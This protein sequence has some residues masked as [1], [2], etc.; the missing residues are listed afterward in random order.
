MIRVSPTKS[1]LIETKRS[2][3]LA[4]EGHTLLDKKR[5]VLIRE[6]MQLIDEAKEVQ[7]QTEKVFEV[8][9]IQSHIS[10]GPLPC[11]PHVKVLS[12]R[13]TPTPLVSSF[14]NESST[15]LSSWLPAP[16]E[17]N[18][19]LEL[20]KKIVE[21]K[22]DFFA[23]LQACTEQKDKVIDYL[24]K[25]LE[26]VRVDAKSKQKTIVSLQSAVE[27]L[28]TTVAL[29]AARL[30]ILSQADA[31]RSK[32]TRELIDEVCELRD[33]SSALV[34]TVKQR[35]QQ[36][37]T[38][39]KHSLELEDVAESR[40]RQIKRVTAYVRLTLAAQEQQAAAA[41]AVAI[42]P[43]KGPESARSTHS[44]GKVRLS[45]EEPWELNVTPAPATPKVPSLR[46]ASLPKAASPAGKPTP[47][48][49]VTPRGPAVFPGTTAVPRPAVSRYPASPPMETPRTLAT[50][51]V[52]DALRLQPLPFPRL[53]HGRFITR[54]G[55]K[56]FRA[57]KSDRLRRMQRCEEMAQ[58]IRTPTKFSPTRSER[59][60]PRH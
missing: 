36:I 27:D 20:K 41:A 45:V 12:H 6:L 60:H 43:D 22:K 38:L 9:A 4:R 19:V 42:T 26:E 14:N 35:E 2:L 39:Q 17:P 40:R 11:L 30:T 3:K 1:K 56:A 16:E 21:M 50:T 37:E 29:Q 46:M 32:E 23:Q 33:N 10:G 58:K 57:R 44:R 52:R 53:H 59:R 15:Q 28:E 18:E 8:A 31:R 5:N 48:S 25:R 55:L 13:G 47:R 7:N 34:S 54:S 51:V 49:L 24:T